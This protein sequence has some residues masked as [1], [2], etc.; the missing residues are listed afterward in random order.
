MEEVNKLS[1]VFDF[2]FIVS[3]DLSREID[4]MGGQISTDHSH[5]QRF[6]SG[7]NSSWASYGH[8]SQS[9]ARPQPYAPSQPYAAS[10]YAPSQHHAPPQPYEPPVQSYA[11][12]PHAVYGR[13]LE[14]KYSNIADNYNSLAQVDILCFY[15]FFFLAMANMVFYTCYIDYSL[16]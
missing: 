1:G 13:S 9:Y 12:P 2:L 16:V 8:E 6:S 10:P 15:D 5:R 7:S 4:L 11:P 3:S 14:R